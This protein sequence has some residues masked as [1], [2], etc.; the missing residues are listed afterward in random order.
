MKKDH[1]CFCLVLL[2][3]KIENELSSQAN[4][5]LKELKQRSNYHGLVW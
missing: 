1:Y 3:M 4:K 5:K 2:A